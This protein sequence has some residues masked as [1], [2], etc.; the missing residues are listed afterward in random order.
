MSGVQGFLLVVQLG[1]EVGILLLSI[2]EEVSLVINLLSKSRYHANVGLDSAFIII[3]HASLLI[4]DSVEVLL[5]VQQLVLKSFVFSFSLSKLH[6]F[7]SKL[8]YESILV[9]LVKIIVAQLAFWTLRH[10]F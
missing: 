2:H 6:G 9:I 3:F 7:L 4:G 8:G 1:I 5:Q 10:I